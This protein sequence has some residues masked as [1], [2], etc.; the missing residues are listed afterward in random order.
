MSDPQFTQTQPTSTNVVKNTMWLKQS[1][2]LLHHEFRRGE[3]TIIFLA[4]VLAV[5]TV[6]SL[7]GFSNQIKQA[8]VT[9]SSS[10]IAADRVLRSSRVVDNSVVEKSSQ[11]SLN[12]AR[13]LETESMVFAGDN[14]L[15]AELSA[16]SESYPLRGE[17]KVK[18]SLDKLPVIVS[19]PPQGSVWVETS[20]L[21]RLNVELGGSLE[22]GVEK[23]TIAG[24]VTDI[25]DR[26]YRAFIIGPTIILNID[27]LPQTE[28]IQPGSRLTYKYLFSGAQGDIERFEKWLK[29]QLNDTMNF[30]DA[31]S[32]QSRLSDT[33]TTA[34]KFLSL[35]SML[36]IILAAVAVAVASRRYGQRHQPTVAVFKALGASLSHIKKLYYLHWSLL[37]LLS[38]SAGLVF[39]YVLLYFGESAIE[40]YLS[41]KGVALNFKPFLVAITTGVLCAVAFAVQPLATLVATSPLAVIRGFTPVST[42]VKRVSKFTLISAKMSFYQL[43]PL[44]AL[45]ALLYIFSQ[46]LLMSIALL[47]GGI[48]VSALLLLFGKLL[49]TA[50][51]TVGSNAGKSWHLALAN[52]KRR[53]SENSVQ[54]VSFTIAIQLLL[55]IFVLKNSIVSEWQQ[56]FPENT[57]NHY[58][59]NISQEQLEPIA[60]FVQKNAIESQGFYPVIRGRLS[61]INNEKL[62]SKEEVD[63]SKL[64][65]EKS[66]DSKASK[67]SKA[68]FGMGRELGLTWY[69][70]IPYDNK[71]TAGKWWNVDDNTPQ[72]SIESTIAERLNIVLGD[73]LTFDIGGSIFIAPVTSIRE[74]NWQNRQLNF[75]MIFNKAALVDFPATYISAWMVPELSKDNLQDFLKAF[76]TVTLMDFGAILTQLFTVI[77]QVSIA[78]ELILILVVLAGSLVLVAQVQASMEDRERELAILKTLGAKG[79]LLRNSILFEF[80]ALGAI[81]GFMASVAMELAVFLLQSQL[82]NM[83]T[84]FHFEYWLLGIASG[85]IFVGSIGFL[86]CWRLLKLSSVTLIR[87]TM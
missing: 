68:R 5:A 18:L 4:I 58:L 32:A 47:L 16:V 30:Y 73:H 70:S 86:S 40:S 45:F 3:L 13:K 37:S 6:F 48:I 8:L 81:A 78:L 9:N 23:F 17:L 15:L 71:I 42:T 31:K 28:L 33:L 19:A 7:T 14:M 65:T 49:M 74:V 67:A 76:P 52:L 53:A 79:S 87:R 2:R 82:F 43:I 35:A 39:G 25:P 27:D 55:L 66:K 56:Q 54:L 36:G 63:K 61:A 10:Y 83:P 85:A 72:V 20:V 22:I 50:G 60:S 24:I 21:S 77:D 26:S 1:L 51:R 69:D 80:V 57:P 29:P 41:L 46:N 75:I 84:S 62:V 38:I 12:T 11:L 59:I 34:E 64:T 44:L